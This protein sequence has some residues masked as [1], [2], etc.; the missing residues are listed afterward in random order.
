MEKEKEER[1]RRKEGKVEACVMGLPRFLLLSHPSAWGMSRGNWILHDHCVD[2]HL[3]PCYSS[4]APA[5][6]NM[7][8]KTPAAKGVPT[9]M[10][11]VP[12]LGLVGEVKPPEI[13]QLSLPHAPPC[14]EPSPLCP[15]KEVKPQ[16]PQ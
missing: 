14:L 7:L 3:S 4:E 1:E 9:C 15:H 2:T 10:S 13:L 12:T 8:G 5:Q 6:R 11:V 16:D